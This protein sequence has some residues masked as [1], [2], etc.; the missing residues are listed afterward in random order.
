MEF[1]V[2]L[3]VL[4]EKGTREYAMGGLG[5]WDVLCYITS[6]NENERNEPGL[7][8]KWKGKF[9]LNKVMK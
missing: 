1:F 8:A 6:D 7:R 3:F 2:C 5:M 4:Q 9:A